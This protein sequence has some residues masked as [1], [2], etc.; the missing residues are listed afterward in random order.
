MIFDFGGF[1]IPASSFSKIHLVRISNLLYG[2][3]SSGEPFN[4]IPTT[5]N[6]VFV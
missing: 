5:I 6:I 1:S 4:P 2:M 3:V